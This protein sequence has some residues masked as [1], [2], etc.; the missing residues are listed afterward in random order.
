MHHFCSSF[1]RV[2]AP[3]DP[4]MEEPRCIRDQD[5]IK[6][7][8]QGVPCRDHPLA[9]LKDPRVVPCKGRLLL[10]V[11][12]DLQGVARLLLL[13]PTVTSLLPTRLNWIRLPQTPSPKSPSTSRCVTSGST[14]RR[15]SS[16]KG[17]IQLT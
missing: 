12:K 15:R 4:R 7:L 8:L 14:V 3:L 1:S 2:R 16:S 17:Q 10:E 5:P 9:L 11:S 6:D 13:G